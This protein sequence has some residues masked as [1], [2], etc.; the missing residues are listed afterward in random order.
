MV[1]NALIASV[2]VALAQ[3]AAVLDLLPAVELPLP[4]LAERATGDT[5][6]LSGPPLPGLVLRALAK[7]QG[8]DVP[9]SQAGR[10]G[11][12]VHWRGDFDWTGLRTTAMAI[13]RYGATPWRMSA[14]DYAAGRGGLRCQRPDRAC[15]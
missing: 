9:Q 11:A 13:V 6:A 10:R 5:K 4:V 14:D 8:T 2:T 12:A 3:A 15:G 7:W 1:R